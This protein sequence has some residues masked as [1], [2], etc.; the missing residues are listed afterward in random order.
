MG[1]PFGVGVKGVD[2][3]N[4]TTRANSGRTTRTG[5]SGPTSASDCLPAWRSVLVVVAH[6]D[7]ES[8][9]LGAVID[10]FVR[11][12]ADVDVLCLTSGEAST[13]AEGLDESADLRARLPAIRAA[14]LGAAAGELGVRRT[15]LLAHPDGGLAAMAATVLADD[16]RAAIRRTVPDGLLVLDTSGVTGHPDHVTAS[17]IAARIAAESGL[18][19]LGWTLPRRVADE[20]ALQFRVRMDGVEDDDLDLALAVDRDAQRRAIAA[21]RTQATPGSI[22]WRRLELLGD[23]E[24]LRWINHPSV[25]VDP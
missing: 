8:F 25:G 6:P 11:A 18:P 16:V 15:T 4:D 2:M 10:G 7:D 21:H 5:E 22:L 19:V 24:Y 17:Q 23:R 13:L 1:Y 9:G 20:L 12:G 3:A 14:E